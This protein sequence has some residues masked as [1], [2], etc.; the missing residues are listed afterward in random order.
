[1]GTEDRHEVG[2]LTNT[3]GLSK[4]VRHYIRTVQLFGEVRALGLSQLKAQSPM[5]PEHRIVI[6]LVITAGTPLRVSSKKPA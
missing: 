5:F 1:L 2:Y 6:N 3:P 4:L